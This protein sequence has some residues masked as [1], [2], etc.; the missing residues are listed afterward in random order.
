MG[1]FFFTIF[2]RGCGNSLQDKTMV[3]LLRSTRWASFLFA[4]FVRGC[5]NSL[6]DK[7]MVSLCALCGR[8]VCSMW[9]A[10]V[11][12]VVGLCALCGRPVV[13]YMAGLFFLCGSY[14]YL[15]VS[16][17]SGSLHD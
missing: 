13:L 6:Q 9:S 7:T 3:G 12:Y 8:P 5:G 4:I 17:Y 11:L 1:K 2:V 16:G 10:C 15:V 14:L